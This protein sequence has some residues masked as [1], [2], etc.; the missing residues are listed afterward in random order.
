MLFDRIS[1]IKAYE[2]MKITES[3]EGPVKSILF[4]KTLYYGTKTQIRFANLVELRDYI[5]REH[6]FQIFDPECQCGMCGESIWQL[7]GF[8]LELPNRRYVS[9][10]NNLRQGFESAEGYL[11]NKLSIDALA[12]VFKVNTRLKTLLN[13]AECIEYIQNQGRY[14]NP[15]EYVE[16]ITNAY[17]DELIKEYYLLTRNLP[18][19]RQ[20]AVYVDECHEGQ[21]DPVAKWT[22][23]TTQAPT[24]TSTTST[25]TQAPTTTTS[26]TS[27]TSTTCTTCTT[28]TTSTSSRNNKIRK[29][30]TKKQKC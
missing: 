11:L 27:T 1:L 28:C 12:K 30:F 23:T 20:V 18:E 2:A 4:N 7:L 14:V 10:I 16:V 15:C 19:F 25:T 21:I 9:F 17:Y 22:T 8:T 26:T 29:I 6:P 3:N 5:N 24:T 13:K